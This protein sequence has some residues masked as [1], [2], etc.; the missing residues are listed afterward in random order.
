MTNAEPASEFVPV[1]WQLRGGRRVTVRAI[2]PE[3][4]DKLQAA[5]RGLSDQS[6]YFRFMSFLRELPPPLLDLATHPT[7]NRE[8]QLVAVVGDGVDETIV[9]GARYSAVAGSE[10]CEFA[11]AVADEWHGLGLARRL[12]ELLMRSARARGF[13]R[14]E[15][16]ILASN[17]RMLG[18]A[19][20]L[21]FVRGESPEG[22]S[23]RKVRCDLSRIA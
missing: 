3:D 5:V 11:I 18:L 21:G 20:R 1:V 9:A 22:P 13:E 6:R 10:D 17:T 8:L 12:L 19:R 2:R 23:V 7:A 15:G 14:M 4:K 16:F